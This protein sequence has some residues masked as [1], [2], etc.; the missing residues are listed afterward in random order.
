MYIINVNHDSCNQIIC[1]LRGNAYFID[2]Q[3]PQ[4]DREKP[5][6]IQLHRVSGE[7]LDTINSSPG[8][9][10]LFLANFPTNPVVSH[11]ERALEIVLRGHL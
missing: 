5:Q 10:Y 3:T 6:S 11:A 7:K 1:Q 4:N 9:H 2:E 8:A